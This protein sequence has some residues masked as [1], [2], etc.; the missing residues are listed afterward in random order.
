[1]AHDTAGAPLAGTLSSCFADLPE[2]LTLMPVV[3]FLNT[4]TPPQDRGNATSNPS[5]R[6]T[7]TYEVSQSHLPFCISPHCLRCP[8]RASACRAVILKVDSGF[9]RH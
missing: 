9:L 5:D 1:M 8:L 2:L 6:N 7:A 3:R 4:P